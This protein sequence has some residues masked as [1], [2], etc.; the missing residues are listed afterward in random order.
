ME[1]FLSWLRRW[2]LD[3]SSAAADGLLGDDARWTMGTSQSVSGELVS[4]PPPL[5]G[6]LEDGEEQR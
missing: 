3:R 6:D 4:S 2:L 5:S 1:E